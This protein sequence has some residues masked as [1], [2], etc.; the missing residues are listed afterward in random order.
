MDTR[1]NL[2]VRVARLESIIERLMQEESSGAADVLGGLEFPIHSW[3]SSASFRCRSLHEMISGD[4]LEDT[5]TDVESPLPS[6][7]NNQMVR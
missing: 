5:T 4:E 3:R 6:L 2:R 1:P 7:L